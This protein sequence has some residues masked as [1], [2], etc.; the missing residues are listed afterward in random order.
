MDEGSREVLQTYAKLNLPHLVARTLSNARPFLLVSIVGEQGVGKSTYAYYSV[1]VGLMAYICKP[2]GI[3]LFEEPERCAAYLEGN[4]GEICLTRE[5]GGPDQLD[6]T[7]ELDVYTGPRGLDGVFAAASTLARLGQKKKVLF[8]DDV[9]ARTAYHLGP[10]YRVAYAALRELIRLA[11]TV[12]AVVVMTAPTKEYLPP[13]APK[14]G[15]FIVGRY[16]LSER[17]FVRMHAANYADR[18]G[19]LRRRLVVKYS[20]AVPAKAAF[21]MPKWLEEEITKRKRKAII[22]IARLGRGAFYELY[23]ADAA[24]RQ[25]YGDSAEMYF[26]LQKYG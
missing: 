9:L 4:Y 13:E 18:D 5:C 7:Y 21:G 6:K 10:K 24:E 12:G 17:R 14:E 20:D 15:E 3:S 2:H 23:E 8:L 1:K 22:D 11:R 26:D 19:Y 25:L 16:G